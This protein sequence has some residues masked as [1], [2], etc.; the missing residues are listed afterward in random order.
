MHKTQQQKNITGAKQL[1]TENPLRQL[2]KSEKL[3]TKNSKNQTA[4]HLWT[5]TS[6][7]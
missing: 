4:A 7:L 2:A 1:T 5:H 6:I 3:R